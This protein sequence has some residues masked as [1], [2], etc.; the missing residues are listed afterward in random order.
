MLTFIFERDKV[1][2]QM[3]RTVNRFSFNLLSS[4][5]STTLPSPSDAENTLTLHALSFSSNASG[6]EETLGMFLVGLTVVLILWCT[7]CCTWFA[8]CGHS[9][10]QVH[11]KCELLSCRPYPKGDRINWTIIDERNPM[12]VGNLT[13]QTRTGGLE[14]LSLYVNPFENKRLSSLKRTQID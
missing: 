3:N 13:S 7:V 1:S 14:N 6:M 10:E 5:M 2:E 4:M 11:G 9:P 8:R 12:I